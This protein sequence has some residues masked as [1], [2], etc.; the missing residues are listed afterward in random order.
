MLQFDI[1]MERLKSEYNVDAIYEAVDYKISRW[2]ECG[3]PKI[4][5]S[6]KQKQRDNIALDAEGSLTFLT[7]S[8]WKL[9]F[10]M[11]KWPEIKFYKTREINDIVSG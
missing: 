3:D 7:T 11:E 8:Q 6:F 4:L 1:T 2:I 10:T 9:D 5:E